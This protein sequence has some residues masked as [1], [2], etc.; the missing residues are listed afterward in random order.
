MYK[1]KGLS[2]DIRPCVVIRIEEGGT[3]TLL[4]ISSAM[5]LFNSN[6]HFYFESARPEF[7]ATGL[8]KASFCDDSKFFK[9][10]VNTLGKRMGSITGELRREFE[11]WLGLTLG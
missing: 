1:D 4:R 3:V 7:A 11:K 9:V 10:H 5:D 6:T 2:R 8:R